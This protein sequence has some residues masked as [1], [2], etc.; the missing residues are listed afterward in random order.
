[1]RYPLLTTLLFSLYAPVSTASCNSTVAVGWSRPATAAAIAIAIAMAMKKASRA[2]EEKP[3]LEHGANLKAKAA[4]VER[5]GKWYEC[6]VVCWADSIVILK[7]M[8]MSMIES[9]AG[10]DDRCVYI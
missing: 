10:L 9:R 7:K 3:L 1:M 4:A 2:D 8:R 6:L 5:Q